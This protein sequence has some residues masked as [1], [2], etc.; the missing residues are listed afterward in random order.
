MNK[1][2]KISLIIALVAM[3][4]LFGGLIWF[5]SP[6]LDLSEQN[7]VLSTKINEIEAKRND[8][9][10]VKSGAVETQEKLAILAGYFISPDGKV[11][12]IDRLESI[13]KTAG[14][15]YSLN[16]AIDG[17]RVSFDLSVNGSFRNIYQFLKLLETSGYWVSFDH[18]SLARGVNGIWSGSM[19]V[20]IPEAQ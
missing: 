19:V 14:V 5:S 4:F 17:P 9:S 18:L 20:N 3:L 13:A 6:T 15:K 10:G 16:N 1:N 12:A 2:S 11:V 8:Y 7:D